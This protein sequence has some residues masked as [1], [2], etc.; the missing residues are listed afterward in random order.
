MNYLRRTVLTLIVTNECDAR[1]SHC[2]SESFPGGGFKMS[3]KEIQSVVT[4]SEQMMKSFIVVFTGGEPTSLGDELLENI[5]WVSNRGHPTRVVTNAG[6]ANST[7]RART[8][9]NNLRESGL[10]EINF[11]LDDFHAN[12]IDPV[13]VKRAYR[14]S[15]NKGFTAVVIALAQSSQSKINVSWVRDNIDPQIDVMNIR[16]FDCDRKLTPRKDGTVYS[17]VTHEYSRIGRGRRLPSRY[18]DENPLLSLTNTPCEES[19][20]SLT[21][22]YCGNIAECCGLKLQNNEMLV[23]G[24]TRHGSIQSQFEKGCEDTTLRILREKGPRYLLNRLLLWNPRL[25]F[26]GKYGSMCEICEDI[27]MNREA[28]LTLQ[29]HLGELD[30]DLNGSK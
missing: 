5:A 3:S 8:A 26:R 27:S 13:C 19:L 16:N 1:C 2:L 11:S 4:Q 9:I 24:N 20:N 14:S 10:D 29:D 15:I 30:S 28:M 7:E 12:W 23:V 25:S 17:L 22:D 6:W 21:V 18:F